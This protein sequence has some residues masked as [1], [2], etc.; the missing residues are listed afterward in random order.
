MFVVLCEIKA[1]PRCGN[2]KSVNIFSLS[3]FE[4]TPLQ[5]PTPSSLPVACLK[6]FPCIIFFTFMRFILHIFLVRFLS[7]SSSVTMFG[8]MLRK[9]LRFFM[10]SFSPS[11]STFAYPVKGMGVSTL[12]KPMKLISREFKPI[13]IEGSLSQ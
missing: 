5:S 1:N 8:K 4:L 12:P 6:L 11:H 2:I 9:Y 3:L 10:C 7:P 13:D